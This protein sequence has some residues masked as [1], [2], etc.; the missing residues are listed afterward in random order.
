LPSPSSILVFVGVSLTYTSFKGGII[1]LVPCV[2]PM[3]IILGGMRVFGIPVSIDHRPGRRSSSSS[4]SHRRHA[5]P[6][7]PL[8]R[9]LPQHSHD[10]AQR[11]GGYGEAA[12]PHR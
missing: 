12:K 5:A 10:Y 4:V 9:T 2:L 7:F 3:V 6:V 1:A 8:Q 11:R